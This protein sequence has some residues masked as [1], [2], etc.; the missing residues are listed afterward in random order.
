MKAWFLPA[1]VQPFTSSHV[2]KLQIRPAVVSPCLGVQ[3]LALSLFFTAAAAPGP[4]INQVTWLPSEVGHEIYTFS[5]SVVGAQPTMNDFQWG[6]L[7]IEA[8]HSLD[9]SQHSLASWFNFSN[10][11]NPV[12]ISQVNAANNKPHMVAFYRDRMIDGFQGKTF[13]IWDFD[14][15]FIANTYSGSVDPVWYMC[16][17]PYVFRPRNGYGTGGNLMEIADISS[18]NGAQLALFDLGSVLSFAVG[19]SHAVGNL[20]IC[21]ASQ[22]KGVAVFDIG[23][24]ANPRLLSQLVTCNP[25]YTSMV[26]SNRIYQCETTTG[27]RVYDF[28]DP[29]NIKLVGFVPVPDNPRYVILRDGKGY[30]CPGSGKLVVFDATTLAIQQTYTLGGVA[31]F[32]QIIGNMAITGG[33]QLALCLARALSRR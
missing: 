28:S 20:L 22:A 23:D 15:K 2:M 10:P 25:V 21:S 1:F 31:D 13:N 24:P 19:S 17:F 11:R 4:G 16:Q 8:A 5:N 3:L 12:L 18:G 9:D 26:H 33:H 27:I 7:I 30:C 14:N 6:Y 29:F 32:A